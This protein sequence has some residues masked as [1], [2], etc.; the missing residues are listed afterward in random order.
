MLTLYHSNQMDLL[1]SLVVAL[2]EREPLQDPFA[3][4]L[5][6][7]Q[8]PGM[9]Q[10]LKI[11]LAQALGISANIR[12]PL[13]A[14]FIWEMFVNCLDDVPRQSA[15]NKEAMGWKLMNL[16]PSLLGESAFAPLAQY[17]DADGQHFKRYQLCHKIADIF[18]Q[19]LVYRPEWVLDWEQG[20][21]THSEAH[22]WQPVLWRSL[23]Q[24]T[25]DKGQ[26]DYHRANLFQRF[27]DKLSQR[28]CS[29]K[30]PSRIF[31]FGISALPPKYMEALLALGQQ[32]QVHLMFN[33][34][35]QQYWG[36]IIDEK[37]LAKLAIRQRQTLDKALSVSGE[38]ALAVPAKDA[39]N[40]DGILTSGNPLLASMG[41]LG[42]DNFSL[43]TQLVEA[44]AQEIDAFVEPEPQHLLA[45]IQRDILCL[46]D[47]AS[48]AT[49]KAALA[50]SQ[51]KTGMNGEDNSVQFHLCHSPMREVEVLH[52]R[53]LAMFEADPDLNPKDV[54]VM[55]PDVNTY[56]PYIQ[57]VF[58]SAPMSRFIPFAIADRAAAT[59]NPVLLSFLHLIS[60]NQSRLGV[61][62]MLSLLEVPAVM[63][64]F[65]IDEQEFA[66]AREWIQEAGVRWG[67]D[68]G[69]ASHFDLPPMAQHTW[70]FGLKRMLMGYACSDDRVREDILPLTQ[71][72]GMQAVVVGK[73]ADFVDALEW[74]LETL[75]GAHSV[76]EW[77]LRINALLARFYAPGEETDYSLQL[78]RDT[79]TRLSEQISQSGYGAE[80]SQEIVA[81]YLK[82]HLED[83]RSSQRF[84]AG[85]VNFCTLMPMRAIPFKVI[86]LLGMNDG[87]YPR[88]IAAMGFDLM[89][90]DPRRGDRSRRDDDRYLFLEALL[91]AQHTLYISYLGWNIK[92]NSDK[93]PSVLV[94]E[95]QEY[96]AAAYCLEQDL[97][98]PSRE[99]GQALLSHLSLHHSL[100]PFS[101]A[102]FIAEQPASFAEEWLPSL[103]PVSARAFNQPLT[104]PPEQQDT[105]ELAELLGFWRAPCRYFFQRRLKVYFNPI[106]APLDDDEPFMLD[107]LTQFRLKQQML[108]AQIHGDVQ[109]FKRKL[110]NSGV[111]PG[112]NFAELS[113]HRLEQDTQALAE[114]VRP[115]LSP[116]HQD[117]EVDIQV[118]EVR[119]QG[120]LLKCY[121]GALVRYRPGG[122]NARALLQIWLEF[123][124]Y[125]LSV[126][127]PKEARLYSEKQDYVLAPLSREQ[128]MRCLQPFVEGFA[129][130]Q[131]SPLG[132]FPDTAWTWLQH[133]ADKGCVSLDEKTLNKATDKAKA[134]FVGASG[135]YGLEGEG[136]DVYVNRVYPEWDAT[137][138]DALKQHAVTLLFPLLNNLE[139]AS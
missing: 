41:K 19:Y 107:G 81:D 53:L 80:L 33:N 63:A 66:L 99:S 9:A 134:R 137:L 67:L 125:C 40:A 13:P 12:F 98:L 65:D 30:L 69:Y 60:L 44:G 31:V 114:R 83:A 117:I 116:Q 115:A 22:P 10:W 106:E 84:L 78:I 50:H 95:L 73:L 29:D 86:C 100:Q 71:V 8:S 92:D 24:D 59:E 27:I 79:L 70:W 58:A 96:I 91:A 64:R 74:A 103:T 138:F 4:E 104:Q 129:E 3:E 7:V 119:L 77:N 56:N 17:L 48:A 14:S 122:F 6:L 132:F 88:S 123:L 105:L 57:A 72:E 55:M 37:W 75:S 23:M 32:T 62:Q 54:V 16:L 38:K 35:C 36:D 90:D 112:A 101:A 87:V 51:H 94:S 34:P 136:Q 120:W 139:E 2:I 93:V 25:L 61:S 68:L 28:D 124:C 108:E 135:P 39:F 118:G 43:M 18:D 89:S 82:N 1:K 102:N 109:A 97:A 126:A 111:L 46:Q 133:A 128:A 42:R 85:Q 5:I 45:C 113:L 76:D 11:E 121:H 52:D 49:D 20:G 15:F 21:D 110:A 47:P 130:G 127:E 131:M 26:S